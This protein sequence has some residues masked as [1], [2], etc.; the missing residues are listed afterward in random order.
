MAFDFYDELFSDEIDVIAS[1]EVIKKL[2]M[3]AY[4]DQSVLSYFVHRV[5]N[6]L[7]IDEFNLHRYLL[8]KS[9]DEEWKWLR[10]FICDHVINSTLKEKS[11]IPIE[12][13]KTK[14]FLERKNLLS[15]FLYYSI[16][17]AKKVKLNI[18]GI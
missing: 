5:G 13:K 1:S 2:L 8:W 18:P 16:E 3:I 12:H 10:K 6:T 4:N 9:E 17:D 14:E 7:L 11:S 15:K